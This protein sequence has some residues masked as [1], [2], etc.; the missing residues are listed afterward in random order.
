MSK[1]YI[2]RCDNYE[3][4]NV[5]KALGEIFK[6]MSAE[7]I[8]SRGEKILLKPNILSAKTPE[9]AVTTHPA[10][11]GAAAVLLREYGLDL[12]YGDS[13][14]A[15]NPLKA[16]NVCGIA[17]EAEKMGIAFADFKNTYEYNFPEGKISKSFKFVQAVRENDGIV[18]ICKFKT[19]ALTRFTGAIKNQFGLVPGLI[20]AKDH[21]K[22]PTEAHFSAMLA[23]LNKCLK[24][25]LYIMDAVVGMEGNGPSG[26]NPREIKFLMASRDPVALDSVCVKLTGL[27]TESV[28]FLKICHDAGL[29]TCDTSKI[30]AI[31]ISGYKEDNKILCGIADEIIEPLIIKDFKN[32]LQ[33]K[34][35]SNFLGPLTIPIMR[36]F[37]FNRPVVIEDKCTLCGKCADI[38]PTQKKAVKIA[39]NNNSKRV[40]FKYS[41][42][43]RCFCCQETCPYSAIKIVHA[44]LKTMFSP[45]EG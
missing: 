13:P 8:F 42:C 25:R 43:I 30:E 24:P 9:K 39:G 14:A 5:E 26:G 22:Y 33:G 4:T 29:G 37:I 32:A 27:E 16:A 44:P 34:F 18:S 21:V 15:D 38:C 12:S 20:K 10:V 35:S 3:K 6:Q 41:K 19:H 17:P 23:D 11:F 7:K 36:K 1:V 40:K 28:A 2:A 45:R 31:Y